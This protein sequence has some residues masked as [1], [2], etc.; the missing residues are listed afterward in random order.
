ME[1]Y[2]SGI[3]NYII[4]FM[5]EFSTADSNVKWMCEHFHRERISQQQG[6]QEKRP[7]EEEVLVY[8]YIPVIFRKYTSPIYNGEDYWEKV[9]YYDIKISDLVPISSKHCKCAKCGKIFE[10]EKM[11]QLNKIFVK[12]D[13]LYDQGIYCLMDLEFLKM[14]KGLEPVWFRKKSDRLKEIIGIEPNVRKWTLGGRRMEDEILTE[15]TRID[16]LLEL[17]GINFRRKEA[18]GC[19]HF[20]GKPCLIVNARNSSKQLRIIGEVTDTLTTDPKGICSCSECGKVFST[21][22]KKQIHRLVSYLNTPHYLSKEDMENH[23]LWE[24]IFIYYNHGYL[25]KDAPFVPFSVKK[26]LNLFRG[27]EPVLFYSPRFN[28]EQ[29]KILSSYSWMNGKWYIKNKLLVYLKLLLKK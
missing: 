16:S 28:H 22:E 20:I 12:M 27:V 7:K 8:E 3:N 19:N 1:T 25:E 13:N 23:D 29:K 15:Y 11:E 10:I 4:S 9:Y 26:A 18:K 24:K 5:E 6:I 14:W 2:D 17:P 21:K